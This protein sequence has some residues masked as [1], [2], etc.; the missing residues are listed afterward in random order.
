MKNFI[1]RIF[2]CLLILPCALMVV[3]CKNNEDPAD[4]D[5]TPTNPPAAGP[6]VTLSSFSTEVVDS[7]L[8]SK[9]NEETNTFTIEYKDA[10]PLIDDFEITANYSDGTT[11]CLDNVKVVCP[12]EFYE[13]NM[14]VRDEAYKFEIVKDDASAEKIVE[15]FVKVVKKKVTAPTLEANQ[16]FV[17]NK[18]VHTLEFV[19]FDEEIMSVENNSKTDASD[20]VAT[21]SLKDSD[22]YEWVD[23]AVLNF[24]WSIAQAEIDALSVTGNYTYNG[25]LQT[26]VVDYKTYDETIFEVSNNQK[27]NAGDYKVSIEIVDDNYKWKS[28]SGNVIELDW[29]IAKAEIDALSVSGTYIYNG[30]LQPAVIELGSYDKS[31]FVI[32]NN[33]KINAGDYK[34]SIEIVNDNYKWSHSAE[35]TIL[36][37]WHI[38]RKSVSNAEL[39]TIVGEYVYEGET[40]NVVFD[41]KF[42]DEFMRIEG[43][44][45]D[46]VGTHKVKIYLDDNYKFADASLESVGYFELDWIV[47]EPEPEIIVVDLSGYDISD[48]TGTY[49]TQVGTDAK[50]ISLSNL[51]EQVSVSYK[52]TCDTE[53]IESANLLDVGEYVTTAVIELKGA[54]AETHS[55][56]TADDVDFIPI[57]SKARYESIVIKENA[58]EISFTWKIYRTENKNITSEHYSWVYE[59]GELPKVVLAR[60]VTLFTIDYTYYRYD[61]THEEYVKLAEAPTTAGRYKVAAEFVSLTIDSGTESVIPDFEFEIV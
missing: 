39:P 21:V 37:D 31:I 5:D 2:L 3:A 47:A 26:A 12:R 50:T 54:Y 11:E 14:I 13:N 49:N 34:V 9:F 8:E 30:A 33:E 58:I 45:A 19:G 43:G 56:P 18:G 17:Y 53:P 27:T 60:F 16:N 22:N 29:S 23:G 25:S 20:Y 10:P 48:W 46:A 35:D 42:D 41:K 15:F 38:A 1:K 28:V 61:E 6:A 36:V 59:D 55:L 40:L 7:E 4:G 57:V 44:S 24:N 52:H 51:P 32:S